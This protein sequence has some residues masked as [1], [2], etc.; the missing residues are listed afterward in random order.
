LYI[1]IYFYLSYSS[2]TLFFVYSVFRS[3][4]SRSARALA[5]GAKLGNVATGGV[6]GGSGT[7]VE[8]S[9]HRNLFRGSMDG[10]PGAGSM[11]EDEKAATDVSWIF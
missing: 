9:R 5:Y 11:D 3:D 10:Q 6:S 2:F 1:Y 7:G 4:E 8:S